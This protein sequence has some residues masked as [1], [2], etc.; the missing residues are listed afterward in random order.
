MASI[1]ILMMSSPF[2]SP[3]SVH[4]SALRIMDI[5]IVSLLFFE[6]LLKIIST[7]LILNGNSSYLFSLWNIVELI[8][9]ILNLLGV[10]YDFYPFTKMRIHWVRAL[11]LL[12]V[13]GKISRLKIIVQT[14][15]QSLPQL[16]NLLIFTFLMIYFFALI[17]NKFL[18][19]AVYFCSLPFP[20]ENHAA[21]FDQNECFDYGGDWVSDA[22]IFDN[23]LYSLSSLFQVATNTGWYEIM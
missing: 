12:H 14:L 10:I 21:I 1:I 9:F 8:V 15:L 11:R 22:L 4:Q 6:I 17:A 20:V 7:G 19:Q 23:M 13:I 5:F 18:N 16:F 3:N 2:D